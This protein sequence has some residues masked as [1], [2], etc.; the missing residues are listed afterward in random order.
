MDPLQAPFEYT[1][2]KPIDFGENTSGQHIINSH[3]HV[4]I[5][6]VGSFAHDL[7]TAGRPVTESYPNHH[8]RQHGVNP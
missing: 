5:M 3:W 1:P 2:Q 7:T 8:P 4:I 6:K